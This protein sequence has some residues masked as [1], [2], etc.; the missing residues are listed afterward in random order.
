M[1]SASSCW[2]KCIIV[3]VMLIYLFTRIIKKMDHEKK[4]LQYELKKNFF[5]YVMD[6]LFEKWLSFLF[7]QENQLDYTE[8][9]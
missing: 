7:L 6:M 9:I 8:G 5:D 1:V 3:G 4:N 2:S